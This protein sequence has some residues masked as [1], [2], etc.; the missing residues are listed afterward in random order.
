MARASVVF[1]EYSWGSAFG[2]ETIHS[3]GPAYALDS[4]HLAFE[5]GGFGSWA[6]WAESTFLK[7]Y[8]KEQATGRG[9]E[10]KA[11]SYKIL[12]DTG[13]LRQSITAELEDAKNGTGQDQS[14]VDSSRT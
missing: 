11:S 10:D 1:D 6:P 12:I 4:I 5:T 8:K 2:S 7:R 14:G 3:R 9:L 13:Q